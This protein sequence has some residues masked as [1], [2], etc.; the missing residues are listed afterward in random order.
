MNNLLQMNRRQNV[1]Q[2][3]FKRNA[4]AKYFGRLRAW[5][6]RRLAIRELQAMPESLLKDLGIERYQIADVVNSTGSYAR[7]QPVQVSNT[8]TAPLHRA[9]A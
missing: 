9:A 7:V 4:V 2:G 3:A 1:V 6:Q 8:T 5:N